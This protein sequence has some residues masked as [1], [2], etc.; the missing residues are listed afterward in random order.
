MLEAHTYLSG[1]CFAQGKAA[2]D[3]IVTLRRDPTNEHDKSA[4]KFFN[5][6]V[7]CGFVM[8]EASA[9]CLKNND[10]LL[11]SLLSPM[12]A[13][14]SSVTFQGKVVS[15]PFWKKMKKFTSICIK[16]RGE[17]DDLDAIYK[18]LLE[19]GVSC[20]KRQDK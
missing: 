17:A 19:A 5:E 3:D 2:L 7:H 1:E 4:I 8:A 10:F 12:M 6:D 9:L 20:A 13:T 18:S 14:F 11:A 16:M 15:A